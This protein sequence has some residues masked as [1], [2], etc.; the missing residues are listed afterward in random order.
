MPVSTIRG[1]SA[2]AARLGRVAQYVPGAVG[3]AAR[4]PLPVDRRA[5]V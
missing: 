2:A 1:R 5:C 3:P 4:G